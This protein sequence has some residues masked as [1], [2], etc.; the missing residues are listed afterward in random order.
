MKNIAIYGAGGFG[1]E[2]LTVIKAINEKSPTYNF[3]GFFDDNE[4]AT[5]D[6]YSVLGG[7]EKLKNYPT[8]LSI[9]FAIGNPRIKRD[10]I[11]DVSTNIKLDY[12][13]LIHPQAIIGDMKSVSIGEGTII[14]A[15]NIL[16]CDIKIGKY[17]ILNL[18]CTVGHDTVIEDYTSFMPT[19]NIS[20]EVIIK[21]AV[22][23]GTGAKIINLVNIGENSIIGA[24]AVVTK[25]IPKEVTAVGVPAKIISK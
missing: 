6:G 21:E 14:T 16:T 18:S 15:G 2:V 23:V 20:G 4:E 12:P 24:G 19:V 25:N 22:Y 10:I 8:S 9:V 1:R 13:S 5:V 7:R 11:F 3:V 17:V